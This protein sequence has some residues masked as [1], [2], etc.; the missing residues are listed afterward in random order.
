[1]TV[2]WTLNGILI[3]APTGKVFN[4]NIQKVDHRTLDGGNTRDYI[5]AEKKV[6]N[7]A[8]DN[9]SSD[10]F[11]ILVDAYQA[12]LASSDPILLVIADLGLSLNVILDLPGY[13]LTLPNHY[14]YRKISAT[15]IEV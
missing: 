4:F 12:Q 15:F 5:G 10:Y 1:M 2:G 6:I 13:E 8:W 7:C 9:I 14:N 3:P 11:Q